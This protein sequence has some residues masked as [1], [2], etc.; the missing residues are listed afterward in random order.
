MSGLE[1]ILLVIDVFMIAVLIRD[2]REHDKMTRVMWGNVRKRAVV[3]V[4]ERLGL[5]GRNV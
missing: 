4:C 5:G 2:K 1:C 3:S